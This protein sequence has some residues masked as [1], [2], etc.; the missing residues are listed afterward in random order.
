MKTAV[1]AVAD[2]HSYFD[3]PVFERP[4]LPN[5]DRMTLRLSLIHEEV[6]ELDV[7]AREQDITG[8]ADGIADAIYVL[9]GMALE[10]GIPIEEVFN[11]VHRSNMTKVWQDGSVRRRSDGKILKPPTYSPADIEAVLH[12][13][14]NS[15]LAPETF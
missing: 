15:G 8:I 2:F 6:S 9:I 4:V 12:R 14:V 7:A 10:Y 5:V 3:L 1:D 11:E 13:A